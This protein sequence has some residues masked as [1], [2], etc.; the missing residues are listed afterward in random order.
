MAVSLRGRKGLQA[1]AG[2]ELNPRRKRLLTDKLSREDWGDGVAPS[3][4]AEFYSRTCGLHQP[5]TKSRTS[6]TT[7]SSLSLSP[8][9]S[10]S[11]RATISS[12]GTPACNSYRVRLACR[13]HPR[14]WTRWQGSRRSRSTRIGLM[15]P[16][17]ERPSRPGG[18]FAW[19]WSERPQAS[20]WSMPSSTS[21]EPPT[22]SAARSHSR[23]RGRA[24]RGCGVYGRLNACAT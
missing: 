21:S 22:R 12:R 2:V 7:S 5:V 6:S 15:A 24:G 19:R 17:S 4:P 14:A 13:N 20:S 23:R 11:S 3:L 18:L 16:E 8:G 10:A 1:S 9:R